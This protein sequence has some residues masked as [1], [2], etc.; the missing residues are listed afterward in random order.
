MQPHRIRNVGTETTT[1]VIV[2]LLE[3]SPHVEEEPWV[4][5]CRYWM[6]VPS[7]NCFPERCTTA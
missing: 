3:P 2:E 7:M 6:H 5:S 1:H 4:H